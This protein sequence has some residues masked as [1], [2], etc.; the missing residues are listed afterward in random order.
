MT[1]KEIFDEIV[2][3]GGNNAKMDVLKKY[4]DNELLRK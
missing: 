4:S 2:L 3:T 1:I